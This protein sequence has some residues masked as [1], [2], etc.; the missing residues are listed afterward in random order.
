M[1]IIL[2]TRFSIIFSK[3][4]HFLFE[5]DR[6]EEFAYCC[7]PK[8]LSSCIPRVVCDPVVFHVQWFEDTWLL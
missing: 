3:I 7:V 4:Q 2:G 5:V 6:C 1:I 8:H